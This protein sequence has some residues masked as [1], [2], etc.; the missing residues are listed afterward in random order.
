MSI[1]QSTMVL[2]KIRS[3]GHWMVVI[4]PATFDS[5]QVPYED[6]F[7]IIDRNSVH[8]RGWD[9]PHV[10]HQCDPLLG[11]DW[12][13]QEFDYG[14]RIEV[15][16]FHTNGLF[17]HYF[18]MA[19]DWRDQSQLWPADPEWSPGS[20][21]YF[22][23]TV[24][25]F[26]EIYEFAARLAQSPAGSGQMH[27]D[28]SINGLKGRQVVFP[29]SPIPPERLYETQM[30]NWPDSWDGSQTELIAMPRELAAH[31]AQRFFTRFGLK[32]S[33]ETLGEIQKEIAR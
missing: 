12:V 4:R 10:D 5:S 20:Q 3:R 25:L 19:A 2:D 11:I 18:A 13:G 28:I 31:A 32:L 27:V 21:L 16:R 33:P 29:T 30:T 14:H 8:L 23:D 24:H 17:V 1:A 26:V 7:A 9:Y 6:L 15:W 22:L